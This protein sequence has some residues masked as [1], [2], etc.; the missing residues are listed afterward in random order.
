MPPTLVRFG[1]RVFADALLSHSD[2]PL[3]SVLIADGPRGMKRITVPVSED[4]VRRRDIQ[5]HIPAFLVASEVEEVV[6]LGVSLMYL[7]EPDGA[8]VDPPT[9]QKAT[10]LTD[11]R[12]DEESSRF[13][14]VIH[15]A[16]HGPVTGEWEVVHDKY[17]FH[18]PHTAAVREGLALV[19][20]LNQPQYMGLRTRIGAVRAAFPSEKLVPEVSRMLE[21]AGL[22]P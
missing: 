12:P 5:R 17:R 1:Q 15:R 2:A 11:W 9:C 4:E 14:K 3:R 6:L 13:A 8:L 20:K 16:G 10:R 19:R 7:A 22:A 18:D 21:G